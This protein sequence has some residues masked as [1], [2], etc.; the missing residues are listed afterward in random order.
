MLLRLFWAQRDF[1][2][3]GQLHFL[4]MALVI[5]R[6]FK[7]PD[8]PLGAPP[9]LVFYSM[10]WCYRDSSSVLHCCFCSPWTITS[11]HSAPVLERLWI[12]ITKW[13]YINTTKERRT[14]W[15]SINTAGM[16]SF[17]KLTS[18]WLNADY[19]PLTIVTI[20]I[21]NRECCTIFTYIW[22]KGLE[23]IKIQP[24]YKPS[25]QLNT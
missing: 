11:I 13:H 14:H 6:T 5:G 4:L 12:R 3:R 17:I 20:F 24:F 8:E 25:P 2:A 21:P 7:S 16:Y 22:F 23:Q 19:I 9:G 1:Q 10:T 18:D 15:L